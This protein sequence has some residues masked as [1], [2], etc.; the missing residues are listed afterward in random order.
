MRPDLISYQNFGDD[1]YWSL[2]LKFNGISNPFSL[3]SSQFLFIPDVQYMLRQLHTETSNNSK[4]A[5]EVKRQYI[6]ATKKSTFD[7]KQ[8]EY[9]QAFKEIKSARISKTNLPPNFTEK[10]Q[11][12]KI[13]H[14]NNL[15]VGE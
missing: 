6:D 5:K 4:I 14:G 13:L 10:T 3:D 2:I 9:N 7:T 15:S 1:S 8:S 11:E 12:A